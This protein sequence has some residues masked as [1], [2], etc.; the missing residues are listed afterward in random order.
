MVITS[1]L[2]IAQKRIDIN[3]PDRVKDEDVDVFYD[4][5]LTGGHIYT[6]NYYGYEFQLGEVVWEY[7]GRKG[8]E[9][10]YRAK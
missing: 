3:I 9:Y 4:K 8:S 6:K 2:T 7:K 1:P 5:H 10:W